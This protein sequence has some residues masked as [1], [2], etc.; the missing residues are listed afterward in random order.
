MTNNNENNNLDFQDENE[1]SIREILYKYL[2]HWKWFLFSLLFFAVLSYAYIKLATPQYKVETDLLIKDN[3]GNLGGQTDLLKDLDLFSSDKIIDNEVQILRSNTILDKVI[4]GLKLQTTYFSTK[5]VRRHE[6]YQDLPFRIELLTPVADVDYSVIYTVRLLNPNEAEINGKKVPVNKPFKFDAG[7]IIIA[8]NPKITSSNDIFEVRFSD[9][10][11]VIDAYSKRL[12]I[13]PVSKQGTVLIITLEDAIPERGKDI[14]NRLIFEYNKAAIE[15][16]NKVTSATLTFIEDRLIKLQEELGSVEKN[17]EQYKSSNQIT[18]ISSQSQIFLQSVQGNDAQLGKVNIQLSV[19]KNI[20]AYL[21]SSKNDVSQVPSMLGIEDPAL[22]GLVTQLSE[23]QLKKQSLLQTIPE[24]NP[25]VSSLNNQ[26]TELKTAVSQSLQ[27]L[28]TGLQITK[29]QL[30]NKNVQFQSVISKVPAKER[31]L[32]DVMRQQEIKNNLFT[33]LLQKREETE[34]SL[35]STAADSRTV[36]EANSSRFPVKPVKQL[37]FLIF[38]FLGLI[39]PAIIIYLRDVLNFKVS[40]RSDIER[41]TKVPILA[42]ISHSNDSSPLLVSTKPRSMVAEQLRALRTNLNFIIPDKTQKVILFTSNISGEGKSFISLNL[43][44]SLA[45]SGKKVVILELDLRKPKLHAGL[46]I[47]NDKGLS[48]YLIG[49]VNYSDI[50]KRIPQ[51]ENYSI[52]TSGPIPP[53]PAELLV[54]GKI[55]TLIEELRKEFDYVLLDAPPV[56][57]VTDAQILAAYADTTI[58]IVRHNYTA[59]AHIHVIENF[60]RTKKFVNLN[61]VI[62]SIEM[63]GGYGYSYGYGYGYGYGGY[64]Q[65]DTSENKKSFFGRKSKNSN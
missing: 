16:K 37:I 54:N 14:L 32:L 27:N 11:D 39:V 12:N 10:R 38:M 45:M 6:V 64:Y 29:Q 53:N 42:E 62:N 55:V 13:T 7:L 50:I 63:Q 20:E 2:I 43:G 31:G 56:G 52:I 65:D 15:D 1:L 8:T 28:K 18:D 47:E 40:K 41:V 21:N 4:N 35:A 36:D 46:E 44:A 34:I 26:I 25:I 51:Q 58:F 49:E 60:N 5:G 9:I 23:T 19:I 33:Y 61:L 17:V 24:T 30:D 59:K 3:N 57:L 22:L 48:N